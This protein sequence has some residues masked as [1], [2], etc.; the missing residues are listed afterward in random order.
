MAGAEWLVALDA[1]LGRETRLGAERALGD[2]VAGWDQGAPW[3]IGISH[4]DF[5]PINVI[6]RPDDTLV[7]LDLDDLGLGPLLL[8]LAWWGWVVR[9]HHPDAWAH[10][11]PTLINGAGLDG[12]PAL[13]S[14]ATAVA[15]IRIV[16]RA[17]TAPD[18]PMCSM[19]L[20]RLEQT[21]DW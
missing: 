9:Y 3:R 11:W 8:D 20:Q 12:G 5:A 1:R 18:E 14:A 19:W 7:L 16:E 13:D 17:A 6:V 2:V 10:G 4:G 15:R 21:A